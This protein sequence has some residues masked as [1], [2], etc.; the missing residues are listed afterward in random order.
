MLVE[1]NRVNETDPSAYVFVAGAYDVDVPENLTLFYTEPN[2]GTLSVQQS[3]LAPTCSSAVSPV[4]VVTSS[5]EHSCITK[6]RK[7]S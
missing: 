7:I 5:L 1:Q 6:R 2:N 4:H 3:A